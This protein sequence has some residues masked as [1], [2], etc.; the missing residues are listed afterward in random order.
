MNKIALNVELA[1]FIAVALLGAVI[2][3]RKA[4]KVLGVLALARNPFA[5]VQESCDHA[6][7]PPPEDRKARRR[8]SPQPLQKVRS[9]IVLQAKLS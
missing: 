7:L 3:W 8:S 5:A 1:S 4:G 9:A 2:T 6:H